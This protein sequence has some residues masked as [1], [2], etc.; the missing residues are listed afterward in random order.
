M[1]LKLF[2]Q[3][4]NCDCPSGFTEMFVVG[5]LNGA[6][7]SD[8][9]STYN[10][11][12]NNHCINLTGVLILDTWMNFTNC[13]FYMNSG[14][15][16]IVKNYSLLGSYS[17]SYKSCTNQ[18]WQGILFEDYGW[19][20]FKNSTI[21]DALFALYTNEN[22]LQTSML[23]Q[24]STFRDNFIGIYNPRTSGGFSLISV[25]IGNKFEGTLPLKI[26]PPTPSE[27]PWFEGGSYSY[28]GIISFVDN[29]L[30]GRKNAALIERNIFENLYCG[31]SGIDNVID[32]EGTVFKDIPGLAIGNQFNSLNSNLGIA[33]TVG[34]SGQFTIQ[35]AVALPLVSVTG[36]GK[37]SWD[38]YS[39]NNVRVAVSS[40]G[41]DCNV[42]LNRME[43]VTTG[44][45]C[46]QIRARR[47]P[48]GIHISDNRITTKSNA[49]IINSSSASYMHVERNHIYAAT[50]YSIFGSLIDL[51][52]NLSADI[53]MTEN[54]LFPTIGLFGVN[55]QNSPVV[56]F[57]NNH[58]N[59]QAAGP[60]NGRT[61]FNFSYSPS[62]IK[63]NSA[64]N[65]GYE[66][67]QT[68]GFRLANS[69][70]SILDCNI[71][72]N[73]YRGYW[74]LSNNMDADLVTN[75]TTDCTHGWYYART[76]I[77]GIQ[78]NHGNIYTG[79]FSAG[80][81]HD[82]QGDYIRRS[83]YLVRPLGNN[84]HPYGTQYNI[85][86]PNSTEQWYYTDSTLTPPICQLN[87]GTV[88][89]ADPRNSDD[90]I[91]WSN[92][93]DEF[94]Q[95]SR[96]EAKSYLIKRIL[97]EPELLSEY[98]ELN[99]FYTQSLDSS[100][101]KLK[102]IE[103]LIS[104]LYAPDSS[105]SQQLNVYSTLRWSALEQIDSI[106]LLINDEDSLTLIDLLDTRDSLYVVLDSAGMVLLEINSDINFNA[107]TTASE[108]KAQNDSI[109][110][111]MVYEENAI[112]VNDIVLNSIIEQRDFDSTELNTLQQIANQCAYSGGLGVYR[113]RALM[114]PYSVQ[115]QEDDI[116][117]SAPEPIIAFNSGAVRK[118][119]VL[120]KPVPA[121]QNL[122][123]ECKELEHFSSI[124]IF[125]DQGAP[126][127]KGQDQKLPLKINIEHW[128]PGLYIIHAQF[129]DKFHN[130]KF[131]KN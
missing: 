41:A 82:G 100:Y 130:L 29:I 81:R 99:T 32:V 93:P 64:S 127:W 95:E 123:I 106:N 98:P 71:S 26:S 8:V 80:A 94:N 102:Q 49:I 109:E 54:D 78:E 61:S 16:I 70:N 124:Q 25:F 86:T 11:Q 67:T 110:A 66:S 39:F 126:I 83:K 122:V 91:N 43:N 40:N 10:H 27:D 104:K 118:L 47:E 56:E 121:D 45:F 12:V 68:N 37:N 36:F 85:H 76:G 63:C 69:E 14:A 33:G 84:D 21:R 112:T 23:V 52:N 30:I 13:R 77:S 62:V 4:E 73:M 5:G 7:A 60:I 97:D 59:W 101:L 131:I 87:C 74:V 114:S 19:T 31:V 108:I 53:H 46:S 111:N 128:I 17:T 55:I 129:G 3:G 65:Q 103:H 18:M 28:A 92:S 34:V 57:S 89:F 2:T 125:N 90:I 50:Q 6:L 22:S 119:N 48:G 88:K 9:F 15:Q 113:A 20:I 116:L 79:Q 107:N 105:Q 96:W 72:N 51:N 120:L 75:R 117:C 44:I 42:A 1:P 58:M 24:K 35:G 115:T 38:P